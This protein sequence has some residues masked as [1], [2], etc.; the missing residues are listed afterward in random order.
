MQPLL[1]PA[2]SGRGDLEQLAGRQLLLLLGGRGDVPAG[3]QPLQDGVGLALAGVPDVAKLVDELLVE[4][5]AVARLLVE[6]AEQGVFRGT[7]AEV[8]GFFRRIYSLNEY[9]RLFDRRQF[10][11]R[12]GA[13]F[14]SKR[15]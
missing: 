15:R 12:V 9:T 8:A 7:R 14:P 6:E 13:R 1:E 3:F 11:G 10:G 4:G 5:V 2:A